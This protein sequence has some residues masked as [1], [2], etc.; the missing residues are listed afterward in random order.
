M[1]TVERWFVFL[2]NFLDDEPSDE[3]IVSLLTLDRLAV[4]VEVRD[5]CALVAQE[6]QDAINEGHGPLY[7]EHE[8]RALDLAEIVKGTDDVE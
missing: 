7:V 2:W 6:T 5:R 4:A 1:N 3:D 8:I